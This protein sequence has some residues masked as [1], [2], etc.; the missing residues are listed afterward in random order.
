LSS[1]SPCRLAN[2]LADRT[3]YLRSEA[4]KRYGIDLFK[5]PD[6]W[7]PHMKG[8]SSVRKPRDLMLMITEVALLTETGTAAAIDSLDLLDSPPER[9]RR[10]CEWVVMSWYAVPMVHAQMWWSLVVN[11]SPLGR[12]AKEILTAHLAEFLARYESRTTKLP[13]LTFRAL[14]GDDGIRNV[15]FKRALCT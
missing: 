8:S 5:D 3:E 2:Q 6:E 14:L 10:L 12:T 11:P 1:G 13:E 4:L 9:D 7:P 15:R